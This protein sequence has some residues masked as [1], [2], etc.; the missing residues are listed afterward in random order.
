[1]SDEPRDG[2]TRTESFT[3][4][5]RRRTSDGT[6]TLAGG[7]TAL[8]VAAR[9]AGR[10]R[11][12]AGVTALAGIGLVGHGL[13]R[14]RAIEG[15]A[16]ETAGVAE[17]STDTGDW[18][19]RGGG[20]HESAIRPE[21]AVEDTDR[22]DEPDA[23][24]DRKAGPSDPR[25]PSEDAGVEI[26]VRSVSTADEPGEATGPDPTQAEPTQTEPTEPEADP[27]EDGGGDHVDQDDADE[28]ERDSE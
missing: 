12:R 8:V 10:S 26:D 3:T 7:L 6:I 1:M 23:G 24:R 17:R 25:R 13:S 11:L 19:D 15:H 16:D 2:S 5:V 22:S 9:S 28:R 20:A 14:R 18:T 27:D 4:T 21:V